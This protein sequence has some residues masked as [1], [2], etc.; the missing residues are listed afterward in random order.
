MAS[1][2]EIKQSLEETFEVSHYDIDHNGWITAESCYMFRHIEKIP[3]ILKIA[4]VQSFYCDSSNLTSLKGCPKSIELDFDCSRNKR[5]TSLEGG[6]TTVGGSYSCAFTSITSLA[7]APER[8]GSNFDCDRTKIENLIGGP[9]WVGRN[10]YC[11]GE[12][13]DSLEGA[14][15]HVGMNFNTRC[16]D[17]KNLPKHIGKDL[18]RR[19]KFGSQ[20]IYTPKPILS[21]N[22]L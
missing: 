15:D 5:L 3:D 21:G 16:S 14:P 9:T 2:S 12:H 8:I 13:M 20:L 10:Y 7:G 1:V 18:A 11:D 19:G 6:P 22:S 17:F 4:H